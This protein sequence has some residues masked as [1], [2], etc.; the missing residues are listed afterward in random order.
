MDEARR[1]WRTRLVALAAAAV[2]L[3]CGLG[4][5]AIASGPLAKYGGVAL[6]STLVYCLVV[7]ARP[8]IGVARAF[9]I[10]LAVSWLVECFQATGIPERLAA[11]SVLSRLVLGTTFSL[12]D[13]PAYLAGTALGAAL[14]DRWRRRG[15]GG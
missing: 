12:P 10:T 13:F 14:H 7:A 6:W 1:S 11:R 4:L 8:G 9:A 2:T 15:G 3:A 5:R